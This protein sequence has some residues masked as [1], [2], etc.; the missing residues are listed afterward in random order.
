MLVSN[1]P[2]GEAGAAAFS[3]GEVAELLRLTPVCDEDFSAFSGRQGDGLELGGHAADGEF[4]AFVAGEVEDF[5]D[6]CDF[7]NEFTG[8]IEEA[9]DGGKE[10][11]FFRADELG[12]VST[13][14]VIIAEAEFLDCDG[15]IFIN[16]GHDGATCE[17]PLDGGGDEALSLDEIRPGEEKLRGVELEGGKEALILLHEADL[18]D[19]GGGL[20]GLDIFWIG[21]ESKRGN[22][23]SYRSRRD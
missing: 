17:K 18:T 10:D 16:D 2:R 1:N 14:G 13:E 7:G 3:G 9:I 12:D 8:F 23:G 15:I 22:S 20:T 11:E 4:P 21:G 6:V 5:T 19:G